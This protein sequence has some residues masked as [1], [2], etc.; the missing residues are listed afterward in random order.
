MAVLVLRSLEFAP[1]GFGN[2]CGMLGRDI[3]MDEAFELAMND[4]VFKLIFID[5]AT[6]INFGVCLFFGSS[7]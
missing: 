2:F 7:R 3:A 5:V 4:F 1:N 6:L